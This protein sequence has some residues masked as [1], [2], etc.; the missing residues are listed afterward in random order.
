MPHRSS[1]ITRPC[2]AR[3]P[4]NRPLDGL[5]KLSPTTFP[6]HQPPQQQP[7]SHGFPPPHC[8]NPSRTRPWRRPSW[9]RLFQ[10]GHPPGR[11]P[12]GSRWSPGG[13]RRTRCGR[14]R[15]T[16]PAACPTAAPGR[17]RPTRVRSPSCR[18]PSR[19]LRHKGQAR[20]R[21]ARL[22]CVFRVL[23]RQRIY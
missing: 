20:V 14:R 23:K 7:V 21:L 16:R 18:S 3:P 2:P 4:K 1:P 13:Y 9:R 15:A 10:R 8:P 5:L 11:P 17:R 19:R 12:S 22:S 6:S